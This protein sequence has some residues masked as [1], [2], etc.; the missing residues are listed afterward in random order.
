LLPL[1]FSVETVDVFIIKLIS[2]VD[3]F[4]HAV[5]ETVLSPVLAYVTSIH[6]SIDLG[7]AVV[8]VLI[9]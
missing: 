7:C 6:L 3:H 9:L 1:S 4:Q 8:I 5:G 2:I